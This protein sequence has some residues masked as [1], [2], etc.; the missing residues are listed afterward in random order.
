MTVD[1]ILDIIAPGGKIIT[2]RCTSKYLRDHGYWDILSTVY[3][4]SS[5]MPET[6]WRLVHHI[7]TRPV[8]KICGGLVKF[9]RHRNADGSLQGFGQWCSPKCRNNDP[10]VLGKNRT[11]VSSALRKAYIERGDS[12]KEKRARSLSARYDVSAGCSPFSISAVQEKAAES[13]KEKYG[14]DNIFKLPKVQ[15]K[16][17]YLQRSKANTHRNGQGIHVDFLTDT[18]DTLIVRNSCPVHREFEIDKQLFYTRTRIEKLNHLVLCPICNPRNNPESSIER[19]VRKMLEESGLGFIQH[20]RKSISPFELDFMIPDKN[21]AIECNGLWW[22]SYKESL[23]KCIIKAQRCAAAGIKLLT[24]WEDDIINKPGIVCDIIRSACKLNT[25]IIQARKCK[26]V[27]VPSAVARKFIDH[28][29]IQGYVNSSV[30]LGLEYNGH[31]VQMMT[32]GRRRIFMKA[33][34]SSAGSYELYRLCSAGNT[35]VIG[36]AERLMSWFIREYRPAEIVSYCQ[37]E[38]SDGEIYRRL[39]FALESETPYGFTYWDGDR[40]YN[41][42]T[43]R[44][45]RIDDGSG[46]TA[47]EIL[48]D[49]G[50]RKCWNSGMYKFVWKP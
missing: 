38:I 36:G 37:K 11:G 45:D 3:S 5:G 28:N 24:F 6:I 44:K 18:G 27:E 8:C 30:R 35:G 20:D 22:H 50:I 32:F 4:D 16:R 49:L 25:E 14:V 31:L 39:G 41:R 13:V 15:E 17:K 1:E 9:I 42:F 26:L 2:Q 10:E 46:R 21:I 19:I 12:I 29:H 48:A 33:G 47:D 34:E 43:Y 23:Q 7:D 40:R